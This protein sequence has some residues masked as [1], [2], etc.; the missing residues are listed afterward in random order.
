MTANEKVLFIIA[1][2]WYLKWKAEV[3]ADFFRYENAVSRIETQSPYSF[4]QE[5]K[6]DLVEDLKIYMERYES[7]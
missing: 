7:G 5:E 1:C 6:F 4:T 3:G 2:Y